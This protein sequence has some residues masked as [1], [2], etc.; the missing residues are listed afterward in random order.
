MKATCAE[1]LLQLDH[2]DMVIHSYTMFILQKNMNTMNCVGW[3]EEATA[4]V[5]TG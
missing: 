3:H 1:Y 4:I 5:D 2:K